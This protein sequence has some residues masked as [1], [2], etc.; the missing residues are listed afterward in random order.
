MC[1]RSGGASDRPVSPS[2]AFAQGSRIPEAECA[3][4]PP[5]PTRALL[6][7][8]PSEKPFENTPPALPGLTRD[9]GAGYSHLPSTDCKPHEDTN[10]VRHMPSWMPVPGRAPFP[11]GHKPSVCQELGV[12]RFTRGRR[13]DSRNCGYVSTAQKSRPVTKLAEGPE[14]T[15][16]QKRCAK[17]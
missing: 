10:H 13:G 14:Q 15:F 17:G 6:P 4:G 11:S 12:R 5:A 16:L 8:S 7:A 2:A 1:A 3:G 9:P